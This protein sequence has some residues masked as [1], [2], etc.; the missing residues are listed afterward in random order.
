MTRNLAPGETLRVDTGCLVGFEATVNYDIQ[1]VKGVK[2]MLF[3]GEGLFY[4]TADRPRPRLDPVAAVQPPGEQGRR[5]RC[6]ARPAVTR[7]G[8]APCSEAS[9]G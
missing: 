7:S 4:A 2:T 8:R 6:R 3:G 5:P 9:A 1:M